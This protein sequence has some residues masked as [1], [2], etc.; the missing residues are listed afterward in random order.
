MGTN[1]GSY[2]F[3][4]PLEVVQ[5][6]RK[7][8]CDRRRGRKIAELEAVPIEFTLRSLERNG[9]S[10]LIKEPWEVIRIS[11][12]KDSWT[13]S[14]VIQYLY[15]KKE[16]FPDGQGLRLRWRRRMF[17]GN[18]VVIS[19]NTQSQMLGDKCLILTDTQNTF[20]HKME[21]DDAGERDRMNQLLQAEVEQQYLEDK[22]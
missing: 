3:G 20:R 8:S 9:I 17:T 4:V 7:L 2:V 19:R 5:N 6:F 18:I 10:V 16:Y 1:E 22:R 12:Q 14:T 11:K 15:G 21:F 13:G